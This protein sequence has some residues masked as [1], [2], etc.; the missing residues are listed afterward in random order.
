MVTE[1]FERTL[2]GEILQRAAEKQ[3][4]DFFEEPEIWFILESFIQMEKFVSKYPRRVHGNL[5][6]ASV[7]INEEGRRG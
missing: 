2:L 3:G 4:A 6:L 7:L 1:A 5:R